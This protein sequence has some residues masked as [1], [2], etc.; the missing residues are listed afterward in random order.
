MPG[1]GFGPPASG[2]GGGGGGG[3]FWSTLGSKINTGGKNLGYG[4]ENFQNKLD[5]G[6]LAA[7]SSPSAQIGLG[8]MRPGVKENVNNSLDRSNDA[9][10]KQ[11]KLQLQQREYQISMQALE[12]QQKAG[13]KLSYSAQIALKKWIA[14]GRQPPPIGLL[15]P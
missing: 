14:E 15:G 1:P 12:L 5:K 8:M 13:V 6:L 9:R 3:G 11:Y 4:I 2:F 7:E 10:D